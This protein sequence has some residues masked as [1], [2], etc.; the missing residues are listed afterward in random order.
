MSVHQKSTTA[1]LMLNVLIPED[2]TAAHVTLDILV[3]DDIAKV[4]EFLET[5]IFPFL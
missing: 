5:N 4:A 2:H 3:T 1:V